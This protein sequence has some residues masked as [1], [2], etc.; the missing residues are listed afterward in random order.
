M[1]EKYLTI[2]EYDK[3][4]GQLAEYTSF[5][6]GLALAH[7]LR[8]SSERS[9]VAERLQETSE[10]KNLLAVRPDITLGGA[11]DVRPLLQRASREAT[12]S[13][14]DLL[15]IRSTLV[16]AR[17]LGKALTQLAADY[18]LLAGK[19]A[20]LD[21][22]VDL[23]D[24]IARCLDDEGRVLDSAS[25]ELARIR[26]ESAVARDRLA[27]QLRRM[28]MSSTVA[29]MLQEPILTERNGRYVVPVK[30]EFRGR[31]PGIIHDQSASGA[32]LFIEPL[33][34]VE[35]NNRWHELQLAERR[36]IDRILAALT[37]AV[38]REA[39]IIARDV[40]L[41][42]E[43]DLALAKAR[44]SEA[45]RG[46]PAE[47]YAGEWPRVSA[48]APCPPYEH[49]LNLIRA[50][51]PLLNRDTVVPIHVYL[52]GNAL[53]VL[54]TGPNTG[55]KTVA[56]KTVGLLAAMNQAGLHIPAADGSRL[57]VFDALYADIGD[58]QSIEQSLSTFSS[59]ITHIV[60]IVGRADARSLVLLDELGAGTDPV[61]GAALAQ[62]LIDALLE[63]RCLML[64]SSHY[65][66]LKAYAYATPYVEN[67]S[68]EFDMRT[69]SPTYRLTIGLPGRSN[70]LAIAE[71]LGLDA[72]ILTRARSLV[73]PEEQDTDV[74]LAHVKSATE[75]AEQHEREAREHAARA[76][77][78]EQE[79]RERLA[80]SERARNQVLD[81]A[82]EEGR[83][84]VERVRQELRRLRRAL[85]S[86]RPAAAET[87]APVAATPRQVEA[88]MDA[89]DTLDEDLAPLVTEIYEAPDTAQ[90]LE[91]GDSVWVRSVQQ[92]GQV[93]SLEGE[94][95][96]V[97]LG[98]LRMRTPRATLEFRGKPA[99]TPPVQPSAIRR[100]L[101]ASPGI[102]LDLRGWRAEEVA[103]ALDRYLN[104]AYLNGLPWVRIIHGKGGGVLKAVV[105]EQLQGHALVASF[106]PGELNEGGDGVTVVTL[107]AAVET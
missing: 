19:A 5:S 30:A 105:R 71:R 40:E 21:P 51:H 77:E 72:D 37:R 33:E 9:E 98:G 104:D 92:L 96:V 73:A 54:I 102:E 26:K 61:E 78:L 55:G 82:R 32:T 12:L 94:D 63:R 44:F 25:A 85:L 13:P 53:A 46:V 69:L 83:A 56:L 80:A 47:L 57:P 90:L 93:L 89:L 1:D 101:A 11:H 8:P 31:I 99:P 16:S 45:L 6:A 64:C 4:L 76:A 58:E 35:L 95:V 38:G 49:P 36:E 15:E 27:E 14:G 74:L 88:A 43:L 97:G 34:T 59:H 20:L 70:A 18:P 103:P 67:A 50:R 23:A 91:P 62:A 79:L 7:A 2:L 107:H 29:R 10:A 68:V 48:E 3:I 28:L 84:E 65:A 100:P 22:L 81:A 75:A 60:D 17:T 87:A 41:L 106:K 39:D 52:G 86:G 42:A 24:E 66:R